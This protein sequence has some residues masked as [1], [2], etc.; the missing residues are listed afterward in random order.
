[1]FTRHAMRSSNV[2][3]TPIP[4]VFRRCRNQQLRRQNVTP[5]RSRTAEDENECDRGRVARDNSVIEKCFSPE[6]TQPGKRDVT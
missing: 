6:Q 3:K 2:R 4:A 1:M 5:E